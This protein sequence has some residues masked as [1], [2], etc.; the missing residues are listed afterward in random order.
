[1][2]KA[3]FL[4]DVRS[5]RAELKGIVDRLD[6]RTLASATVPG[7]AWTAKDVLSHLIG[8]DL[9]ILKALA[10]IRAGRGFTWGWTYPNFDP[11][12]ESNVGPRRARPL[13]AVLA[14]L[15]ASRSALLG[16]LDTWPDDAGPFGPETWDATRSEIGWL[17]PHEREHAEM[18][19]KLGAPAGR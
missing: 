10:D 3:A 11:W 1:V 2:S 7:M 14:E 9:A 16:E 13:P 8:Y 15:E 12:N 6:K 5:A 18:I 4:A 19:A 17:G